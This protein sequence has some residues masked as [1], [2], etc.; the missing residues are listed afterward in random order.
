[1]IEKYKKMHQYQDKHVEN[2]KYKVNKLA[3]KDITL[4]D[5]KNRLIF[6]I[7]HYLEHHSK[8]EV[9]NKYKEKIGC[10]FENAEDVLNYYGL[11]G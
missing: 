10:L 1:M 8:E 4:L 6:E 2:Y 3:E 5:A 11:G 7:R 9:Y